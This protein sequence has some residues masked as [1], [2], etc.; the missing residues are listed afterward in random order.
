MAEDAAFE[1]RLIAASNALA[2]CARA[3]GVSMG[4]M[5]DAIRTMVRAMPPFVLWEA[6]RLPRQPADW[7]EW[8]WAA[9]SF[10]LKRDWFR[11]SLCW[12]E[13][14]QMFRAEVDNMC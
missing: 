14:K 8:L 6:L 12:R 2:V 9:C 4:Q 10:A 1:A 5:V 3:T 7:A 11:A 13:A